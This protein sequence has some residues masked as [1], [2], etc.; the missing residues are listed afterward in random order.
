MAD[1]PDAKT[2][3]FLSDSDSD[4]AKSRLAVAGIPYIKKRLESGSAN[5][6]KIVTI[7]DETNLIGILVK[8]SNPTMERMLH[9]EYSEVHDELLTRLQAVPHI[10]FVHSSFFG[11]SLEQ[12]TGVEDDDDTWFGSSGY[13]HL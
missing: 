10:I 13:F 1:T 4:A 5:W 3:L 2:F 8:L 9:A 6:D 11:L 12:S 7:I